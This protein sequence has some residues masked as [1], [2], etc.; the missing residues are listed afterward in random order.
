MSPY[1][2]LLIFGLLALALGLSNSCLPAQTTDLSAQTIAEGSVATNFNVDVRPILAKHCFPCHGPDEASRA[3]DLRLDSFQGATADLGGYQAIQPGA[4]ADSELVRR[5]E[6]SDPDERMPPLEFNKPL[7][8]AQIQVLRTW[9]ESGGNYQTHWAFVAPDKSPLPAIDSQQFPAWSRNPV[10]R[11]VLKKMLDEKLSPSTA[12]P[13]NVLI[14]RLFLDLVGLPP[15][16]EESEHWQQQLTMSPLGIS[17]F[18]DDAYEQLVDDLLASPHYGERW[19]RRWLDLARYADTNGYEK[20]R[21]RS[22]WPYRDWVIEAFN[23]D[24]PFDQFTIQQLAG[25]LLPGS[26]QNALIATGFHRN[27]MLNEEGGIDPLEYRF[28]AMT[29]RVATT[30][31]TWLGLTLGCAQCHTHKYDPVTHRDYYQ[32]MALLNNTEEP[33]L[34]MPT[35][36]EMQSHERS[37]VEANALIV[38]LPKHWPLEDNSNPDIELRR[39]T[40][41]ETAFELWLEHERRQ[42]PQWKT[43]RPVTASSST[44]KLNVESDDSIF[45]SG[46]ITKDD[47]YT[48]TF[49][50]IA[51]GTTA[52][53]LEVLPDDRLPGRG[54]GMAYFE[55]PKGDFFLGEF[56]ASLETAKGL[57]PLK[58]SHATETCAKNNFGG[59]NVSAQ[60]ALDGDPQTGWSC[61][62]QIGE[63]NVAVFNL[64][65]PLPAEGSLIIALRFGRH[66]PC[67]LGRFRISTTTQV[68]EV[69]AVL[70]PPIVEELLLR[71]SEELSPEENHQLRQYFLMQAPELNEQAAKIR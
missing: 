9:V 68:G 18:N 20:D 53:R 48:L 1:V 69:A 63:R 24:L 39:T 36:E 12:A 22:I 42:T 65:E 27:T 58:L 13:P 5:I 29:D 33:D 11:F 64:S 45:A 38:E 57:S 30:G 55:G 54:P 37:L 26:D 67:S 7:T 35:P 51:T 25:D 3:A 70:T 10:D 59:Q 49:S 71:P 52:I 17:G 14:R 16:I 41:I 2:R 31:T 4:P 62:D 66:Y 44:L 23:R 34:E 61:A 19:A 8:A 21:P 47:L 60:L 46:D 32:V 15:T 40:A 56:T 28:Y 6:E 43:L 50:N